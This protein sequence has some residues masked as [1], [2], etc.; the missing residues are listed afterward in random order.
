[1][2]NKTKTDSNKTLNKSKVIMKNDTNKKI[3]SDLKNSKD[4]KKTELGKILAE[5]LTSE[6]KQLY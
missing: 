4:T 6:G 3:K 5:D 2:N 1:M